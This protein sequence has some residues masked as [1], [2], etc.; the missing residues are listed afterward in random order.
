M[1]YPLSYYSTVSHVIQS[2][3]VF[4]FFKTMK[5]KGTQDENLF[6]FYNDFLVIFFKLGYLNHFFMA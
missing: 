6:F 4:S 2:K 5:S 1:K 3:T